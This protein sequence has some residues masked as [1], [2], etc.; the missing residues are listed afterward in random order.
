M[1][2]ALC[3]P[4]WPPGFAANGIVT[5]VS[6]LAPALRQQGHEVFILASQTSSDKLDSYTYDVRQF[7]PKRDVWGGI[8]FSFAPHAAYFRLAASTIVSATRFLAE[9]HGADVIEIEESFGLSWAI[10]RLKLLPVIVRL[11]GP[12]FLNGKFADFSGGRYAMLRRQSQEGRGIRHADMVTS[13]SAAVLQ[14]VK[15]KYRLPLSTGQVIPN[16]LEPAAEAETWN[17]QECTS[18]NLLYVGR[19]DARKGGDIVIRAFSE[20]AGSCPR[21]KLT[22]VGPDLGLKGV[23]GEK[24]HFE[25]FVEKNVPEAFRPRITFRQQLPHSEVMALRRTHFAT[26]VAS[27]YE[28]FPYVVLEAMSVGCPLVSTAIGGIPEMIAN[29]RNGLLVPSQDVQAMVAACRRLLDDRS[30][31]ARLG[32]QAWQDCREQ[33]TPDK[34]AKETAEL[35]QKAI[36]L[37]RNQPS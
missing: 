36:D 33:F 1:K 4:S 25:Q 17:L 15:K 34:I 30:L 28:P 22:F 10:S 31:A 14:A 32:R 24:I 35:Y 7:A 37:F 29:E 13:P 23:D 19:F 9:R 21:L 11:H 20:L 16:P 27:Q 8:R 2:I 12:W 3:V 18:D 5:Y 6:Q 26:I